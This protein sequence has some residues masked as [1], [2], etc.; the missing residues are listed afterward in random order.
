MHACRHAQ[1]HACR[2]AHTDMHSGRHAQI[3]AR[4]H[5]YVIRAFMQAHTDTCTHADR[6]AQIH[7]R[8]QAGTHRYMRACRHAQIHARMHAGTH[9]YMA[10]WLPTGHLDLCTALLRQLPCQVGIQPHPCLQARCVSGCCTPVVCQGGCRPDVCQGGSS[11]QLSLHPHYIAPTPTP[12]QHR[13]GRHLLKH[14]LMHDASLTLPH[15]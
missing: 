7:A 8:M 10:A 2:Q 6:H 9:R 5:R 12:A 15:V 4:T 14:C 11:W 13:T 3:H 1:I